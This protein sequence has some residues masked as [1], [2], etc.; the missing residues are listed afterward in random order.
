M[1]SRF[2]WINTFSFFYFLVVVSFTYLPFSSINRIH[3]LAIITSS[4]VG[5]ASIY[6]DLS[7]DELSFV[8]VVVVVVWDDIIQ[9]VSLPCC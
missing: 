8:V 2:R 5:I 6:G 7:D 3:S 4:F 9:L 1:S